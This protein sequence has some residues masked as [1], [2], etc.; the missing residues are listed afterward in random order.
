MGPQE[1]VSQMQ[2]SIDGKTCREGKSEDTGKGVCLSLMRVH[3]VQR[4]A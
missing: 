3:T 2:E 1:P 4:G